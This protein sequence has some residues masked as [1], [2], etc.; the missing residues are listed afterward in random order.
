MMR[1]EE[2]QGNCQLTGMA[3]RIQGFGSA[4]GHRDLCRQWR[5]GGARLAMDAN[6]DITANIRY[7]AIA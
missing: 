2:Y 1:E 3:R 6:G 4:R 7:W 5:T